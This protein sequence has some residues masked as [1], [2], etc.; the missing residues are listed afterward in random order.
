MN[1]QDKLKNLDSI[2]SSLDPL[3]IAFSGGVD[4]SF[5][6]FR[7]SKIKGL[8]MTAITVKTIYIPEYEINET[9]E[10][11]NKYKINHKILEIEVPD[12]V[13]NNPLDRCYWCKK[14][15]FNH[16]LQFAANNGFKFVADGT[17]SDDRKSYRPGLKALSEL[18]VKSPLAEANLT[19]DDIRTA[20]KE[21]GIEI[22]NKPSM[23]CLLTRFPYNTEVTEKD[24]R[25]V[26]T[27]ENILFEKGFYGTRVRKHGEIA[28][29]ECLPGFIEKLVNNSEKNEIIKSLKELGFKYITIDLEGYRS[30]SMDIM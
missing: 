19:K 12:V 21:S 10:F 26:E 22:W 14:H 28:R 15:I 27:A 6:V 18:S 23:A 29:I 24:I 17:N 11:C 4:S 25:I 9:Y 3:L 13:K 7:A 16:I 1:L 20:L 5:L 30:G 2:L 8:K